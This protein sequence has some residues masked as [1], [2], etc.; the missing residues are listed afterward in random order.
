MAAQ[1]R[2]MMVAGVDANDRP[3]S[4]V[5][6]RNVLR[7]GTSFRVVH[8]FVVNQHGDLLLQQISREH[9]RHPLLWGAS[10]AGYVAAGESYGDASVRKLKSELGITKRPKL[11]GKTQMRD[12]ESTK[13]I[14]VYA[15]RWD[16]PISP[17]PSD[18]AAIQFRSLKQILARPAS[19]KVRLTPTFR[20]IVQHLRE[21]LEQFLET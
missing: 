10:V 20:H 15:L 5:S 9:D 13:F 14:T 19:L 18:F 2:T 1:A 7:L 12:G 17:N 8:V 11:V 3:V 4:K 21:P 16:G 6:R